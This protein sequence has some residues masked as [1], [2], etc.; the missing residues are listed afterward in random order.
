[1]LMFTVFA[2]GRF[3]G[4]RVIAASLSLPRA[5]W[6]RV[7]RTDRETTRRLQWRD[8]A[9]IR[10]ASLLPSFY[11]GTLSDRTKDSSLPSRGLSKKAS[12]FSGAF[13]VRAG[14]LGGL[15]RVSPGFHRVPFLDP[16]VES[17]DNR[18]GGNAHLLQ[19]LRR[20]GASVFGLSGA[21]G[22]DG[23][24]HSLQLQGGGVS[25]LGHRQRSG[26]MPTQVGL[27]RSHV[28]DHDLVGGQ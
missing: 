22:R 27:V 1:M 14:A 9:G 21:I 13:L 2:R 8:R 16:G 7:T 4:S 25:D 26:N 12:D 19:G 20:T 6:A 11:G 5:L 17:T 18:L 3:P 10:P 24:A 28:D 23:L 15:L